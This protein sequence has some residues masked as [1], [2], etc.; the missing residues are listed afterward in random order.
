MKNHSLNLNIYNTFQKFNIIYLIKNEKKIL[1]LLK[2]DW[3][4]DFNPE[5]NE[6]SFGLS[7]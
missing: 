7:S 1:I 5:T 3:K 6:L 2:I 4:K